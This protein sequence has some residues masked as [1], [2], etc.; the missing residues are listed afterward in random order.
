MAQLQLLGNPV[1]GVDLNL[2]NFGRL[3]IQRIAC[4]Y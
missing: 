2:C 4:I 1:L 3:Y